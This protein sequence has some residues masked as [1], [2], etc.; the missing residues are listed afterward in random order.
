MFISPSKLSD[1]VYIALEDIWK[2]AAHMLDAMEKWRY[3][4]E[5]NHTVD[6]GIGLVKMHVLI[7][8]GL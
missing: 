8:L 1:Y 4:E 5:A 2:G 3:S 6:E 7:G